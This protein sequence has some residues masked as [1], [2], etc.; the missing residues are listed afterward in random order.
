MIEK[1]KIVYID[2]DGVLV[3]LGYEIQKWFDNHPQLVDRYEDCPDHIQ[4]I[5]RNPPP[6]QGAIDAIEKLHESGKYELFIATSAPWGNPSAAMEKRFWIEDHFGTLFHKRMFITH[7]KD[8]FM[9]DYLIDDRTAN[10]A[11]EFSGEHLQFG[12]SYETGLDGEYP[13][14]DN[15]LKKLL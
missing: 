1:K 7:R 15:I 3:N 14:W 8:L 4:G 13:T 6:I 5:F 2:M 10:G 9:G 11:G 12:T